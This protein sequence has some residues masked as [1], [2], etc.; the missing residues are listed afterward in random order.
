M[1]ALA[2]LGQ[3]PLLAEKV[4][5]SLAAREKTIAAAESCTAGLAAN[6]IACVSG[7]S[8][9]FWGSFVTYAAAAKVEMLG[10]QE[11]LI[12]QY[13][14]VSR[15]VA[16]AMAEGALKKSGASW[17]FSITGFAGPGGGDDVPVGTVWVGIA[18][19]DGAR[20]G[21]ARSDAKRF[22]FSGDRNEVR[23]AAAAAALQEVLE[24]ISRAE[25]RH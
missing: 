22:L 20:S 14:V 5:R 21:S 25:V 18:S 11:D 6:F 10:V 2:Y 9:V 3:A 17:A 19:R 24:R 13:G 7:A 15:P 1:P 8:G 16:V 4:V 12:K 23:E